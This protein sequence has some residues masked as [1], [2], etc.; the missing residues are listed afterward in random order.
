MHKNMDRM[1]ESVW[2]TAKVEIVE[3]FYVYNKSKSPFRIKTEDGTQLIKPNDSIWV[4]SKQIER[5]WIEDGPGYSWPKWE[6]Y[7]M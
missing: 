1:K 2:E 4:W 6:L 7:T 5:V 3:G